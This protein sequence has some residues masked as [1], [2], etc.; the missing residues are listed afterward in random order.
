MVDYRKRTTIKV[1]SGAAAIAGTPSIASAGVF[2]GA[3]DEL[4]ATEDI[5]VP[6]NTSTELKIELTVSDEST[7][8]MTNNSNQLLILRHVYPGIVHAGAR[9]FDINSLFVNCAYAISAGRSRTVTIQPTVS[10]Q[11]ETPYP[12]ELYRNRPQRAVSVVGHDDKGLLVNSTRSFF[13]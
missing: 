4:P 10:T 9:A 7:I 2:G 3:H 5:I 12:R 8:R 6:V 13:A 1:I 11:A